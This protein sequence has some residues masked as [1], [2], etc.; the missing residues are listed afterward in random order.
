MRAVLVGVEFDP[1]SLHP[2]GNV[3]WKYAVR[4]TTIRPFPRTEV[5]HVMS[6]FYFVPNPLN[7]EREPL[8]MSIGMPKLSCQ[9]Q[10]KIVLLPLVHHFGQF[11]VK[12][13]DLYKHLTERL[14]RHEKLEECSLKIP[15]I[16]NS[17]KRYTAGEQ[18][19]RDRKWR[20]VTAVS[21]KM[22]NS[23]RTVCWQKVPFED[24]ICASARQKRSLDGWITKSVPFDFGLFIFVNK[25]RVRCVHKRL[26]MKIVRSVYSSLW[27]LGIS[28]C[29][30]ER[31]SKAP[32][33][34]RNALRVWTSQQ[35]LLNVF[36]NS[37]FLSQ[38][39]TRCPHRN[40]QTL[41]FLSRDQNE[42][43]ECRCWIA[44]TQSL[45]QKRD[46]ASTSKS[47]GS[48]LDYV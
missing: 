46:F 37:P 2:W 40:T 7:R 45:V 3:Y 44:K 15:K 34:A 42:K 41:N 43:G 18:E 32:L 31:A 20:C 19:S 25:N 8:N 12:P 16:V 6:R 23:P 11:E 1:H 10:W 9:N 47:P 22:L 14:H 33:Q 30:F 24:K 29:S 21:H 36:K 39:Q 26:T 35:H 13:R 38:E 4:F 28:F 17:Q 48:T 5:V 27:I